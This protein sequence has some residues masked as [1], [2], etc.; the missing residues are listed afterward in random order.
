[1]VRDIDFNRFLFFLKR[2]GAELSHLA[3]MAEFQSA[4]EYSA[5]IIRV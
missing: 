5:G 3:A 1:M 2:L 4:D